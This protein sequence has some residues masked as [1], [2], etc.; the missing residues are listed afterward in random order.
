MNRMRAH[1]AICACAMYA[2]VCTYSIHVV[3]AR[4]VHAACDAHYWF[5]CACACSRCCMHSTY[6]CTYIGLPMLRYVPLVPSIA[7]LHPQKCVS[8]RM[9]NAIEKYMIDSGLLNE[10][11]PEF[12]EEMCWF[13]REN[14]TQCVIRRPHKITVRSARLG[15]ATNVVDNMQTN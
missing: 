4:R 2:Y 15:R 3:V 8:I 12:E 7:H 14:T 9:L 5:Q 13:E 1:I 6:M 11:D 10:G